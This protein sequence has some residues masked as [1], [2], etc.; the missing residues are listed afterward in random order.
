MSTRD[1]LEKELIRY[2]SSERKKKN[3]SFFKMHK[4]SYSEHD[5][6]RG[7]SLPHI[8]NI[9]RMYQDTALTVLEE[10]LYSPFHEDRLLA[11]IMLVNR[12]KRQKEQRYFDFYLK[13]IRQ[14]NNWDLVDVSAHT[15]VGEYLLDHPEKRDILHKL[16]H[17]H[18]LWDRRIAMLATLPFIKQGDFDLCFMLAKELLGDGEDLIHKVLGW[19]LREAWKRDAA[20]VERFL[21][22]HYKELP[23]TTLRYAIERFPESRRLEYLRGEFT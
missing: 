22:K 8:R 1:I 9:A 5:I 12:F 6:F 10:L 15:I 19:M 20:P 13:H 3:E 4:G 7:T 18:S 11:L 16:A 21:K 14:V 23:R 17:S 2:S